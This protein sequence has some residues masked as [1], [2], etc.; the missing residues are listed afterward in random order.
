MLVAAL[1]PAPIDLPATIAWLADVPAEHGEAGTKN[2][3][4]GSSKGGENE[5][6]ATEPAIR[7]T[8]LWVLAQLVPGPEIAAGDGTAR[9]GLRWQVTPLLYSFGIQRRVSPWRFFIVEPIVRHSGSIELYFSPE[10]VVHGS[11]GDSLLWRGGVRTYLPLVER[12]DYL[13]MSIGTSYFHFA[14]QSGA[15]YE[16]GAYTLYG[17]VGVQIAWSPTKGP[18]ETVATLSLR[19]F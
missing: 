10:Y 17:I 13:S 7:V 19:Y 3:T 12:G 11:F 5:E 8:P 15:A 16:L 18:A 6:A 2:D 4:N 1:A 9:F 14:G